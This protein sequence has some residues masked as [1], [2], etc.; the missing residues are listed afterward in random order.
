M[1]EPGGPR[2]GSLLSESVRSAANQ[3]VPTIVLGLLVAAACGVILGTVGQTAAAE[4]DVLARID[5]AGTRSILLIDTEGRAQLSADAVERIRAVSG[6]E[7]VI[8]FGPA[9]DYHNSRLDGDAP[10]AV[11]TVHGD[12]P[13][14]P[15]LTT[16]PWDTHQR[17]ALVGPH[18]Q[19]TLGLAHP[20]G[21]LTAPTGSL[22]VTGWF[23]ATEP[24]QFLNTS[25]IAPPDPTNPHTPLRSIHI[26]TRRPQNVAAVAQA[27]RA[28]AAPHDPT[29]LTIETSQTLAQLRSAVA[30]ELGRYNRQLVIMILAAAIALT[31]LTVYGSVTT[32][33]RDFGRRRALGASRTTLI[34]LVI[35]Q[36][37]TTA[38]I[39]AAI[40]T[41][42]GTWTTWQLTHTLPHPTFTT[43]T[44][45]LTILA[46]ATASL[47]PATIAAYRDPVRILRVP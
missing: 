2:I 16:S 46:A 40:G 31:S 43:A 7:W 27:A 21:G 4:T 11:R 3:P 38:T 8:G 44:A 6:V 17:S 1:A 32:R 19:T 36:T 29:S 25:A 10:I 30:G 5:Q 20:V 45:T 42:A 35:A 28:L 23:T 34:G 14:P 41:A 22:A 13:P 12:L 39:G 26:L 18:A 37:T 15:Y 47:P 24:L 33:R 9:V